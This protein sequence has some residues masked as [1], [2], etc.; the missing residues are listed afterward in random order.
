MGYLTKGDGY[1]VYHLHIDG[2]GKPCRIYWRNYG[3]TYTR[4]NGAWVRVYFNYSILDTG[5]YEQIPMKP[6]PE[7]EWEMANEYIELPDRS[8]LMRATG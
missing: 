8:Y 3:H 1:M 4:V 5:S 2:H 7:G 6:N